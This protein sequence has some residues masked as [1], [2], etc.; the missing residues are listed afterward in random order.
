MFLHISNDNRHSFR[1]NHHL[2][3]PFLEV[4]ICG[5]RIFKKKKFA[6]I[7]LYFM[8]NNLLVPKI[9]YEF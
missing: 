6:G 9:C 5:K 1:L 2:S 3:L 8:F 7:Y 4:P